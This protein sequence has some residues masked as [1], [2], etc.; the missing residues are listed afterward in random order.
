MSELWLDAKYLN[1]MSFRL[2]NFKRV[3]NKWNFSCP[4]CGDSKKDK[5]KAR[6]YVYPRKGKLRY[7]CHNCNV[8]GID[9][10]KLLKHED[11]SLY[12]EYLKERLVANPP[13]KSEVQIFADKM[14][15]PEFVKTTQL[16]TLTKISKFAPESGVRKWINARRI[17][18]EYHYKLYIAKNFK[19]W[20]NTCIAG[21]FE[22]PI[23]NDEPRLII[24]LIDFDGKTL[25]GFQGRSFKKD[26]AMRYITIMLTEDRPKLYG[27][28]TVD[29]TQRI[30]AVEG[31]IDSMFLPNAIAS[32]GSDITTNF[33]EV[34]SDPAQF[35][36]VYDNE[37]RNKETVVKMEKAL[38]KGLRVCIWPESMEQ[39]DIND[40]V[41]AGY[42]PDKIVEIIEE[43][44]YSGIEGKLKLTMWKRV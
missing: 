29:R 40:M 18:P 38:D 43:N 28:D 20:T 30:F 3:Q 24:P 7:H 21:K 16:K 6:G 1:L 14:K 17:P 39:K 27:L 12:S 26:A 15:P 13:E 9:V 11:P 4:F 25:V 23:K 10:P 5:S 31:P 34:S 32:C 42:T 22:E 44:T 8:P 37:P 2:R 33:S 41:L 35:V 36:V 19:Q